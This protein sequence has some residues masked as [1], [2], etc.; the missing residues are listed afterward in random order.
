VKFTLAKKSSEYYKGEVQPADFSDVADKVEI[1]L[2]LGADR[3][4]VYNTVKR[5]ILPSDT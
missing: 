2:T 1:D 3:D 5:Y 4:Q